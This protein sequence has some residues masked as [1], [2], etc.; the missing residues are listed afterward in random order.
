MENQWIFSWTYQEKQNTKQNNTLKSGETQDSTE[1]QA[2]CAYMEKK[3]LD[4]QIGRNV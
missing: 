3:F 2:R 1:S 4:P